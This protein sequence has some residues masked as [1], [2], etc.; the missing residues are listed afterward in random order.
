MVM[1][2]MKRGGFSGRQSSQATSDHTSG[3]TGHSARNGIGSGGPSHS[4]T[5]HGGA[6]PSLRAQG[7]DSSSREDSTRDVN[8]SQTQSHGFQH[9]TSAYGH[10]APNRGI[11]ALEKA[12][13]QVAQWRMET[14]KS[15][16]HGSSE[17]AQGSGA[18]RSDENTRE[19]GNAPVVSGASSGGATGQ[20]G[21][22]A[23]IDAIRANVTSAIQSLK[24]DL[25]DEHLKVFS[26]LG[27]GGFGTVYH[28][29]FF[30]VMVSLLIVSSTSY[31]LLHILRRCSVYGVFLSE[32]VPIQSCLSGR[33]V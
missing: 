17:R 31:A 10:Y 3:C 8:S 7:F 2:S 22:G 12:R 32:P 15:T 26:V 20:S 28:G 13:A 19:G 30:G 25:R 24:S 33:R 4:D 9:S 1:T 29:L 11:P 18:T 6:F 14:A 27:R 23:A 16:P 5:H 21:K